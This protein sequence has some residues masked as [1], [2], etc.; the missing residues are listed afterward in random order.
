MTRKIHLFAVLFI[1]F[2]GNAQNVGIGTATPSTSALLDISS[3]TKGLLIPR[4]TNTQMNAIGSPAPGLLV[5]NL[6]DS[7]LYVR[8]NSGWTKL[9]SASNGW[10]A[11]GNDLYNSNTGNIGIG[12]NVPS[13]ARVEVNGSVGAAVAIFGADKYGVTIEAN[14]PEIGFNYFYNN[15]PK[16]LRPGYAS[17]VGMNPGTGELYLSNFGGA[18]SL[19]NFGALSEAGYRQNITILQT[20]E[21]QFAGTNNYSHFFNGPNEDVYIRSGKNAGNVII[22]DI[23]GGKIGVGMNNPTRAVLEQNGSVGTTAAIFGGDGAGISLQKNWP[24]I[25]FNHYFDGATHR[26]IGQGY[27]GV[28]GINQDN[29]N[30]YYG[31]WSYAGTSNAALAGYNSSFNVTPSGNVDIVHRDITNLEDY[32][33]I[34]LTIE[35][36]CGYSGFTQ[37]HSTWNIHNGSFAVA[38]FNNGYYGLAFW[39]KLDNSNWAQLAAIAGN[40][41]EYYQASD[42]NLKTGI[43]YMADDQLLKKIMLL[44][45]ASYNFKDAK[46]NSRSY[47]FIAQE[48]EQVFPDFVITGSKN[49]LMCYSN[50]IPVLTKG[51]QE[52]QQQIEVLQNEVAELKK[53]ILLK[54]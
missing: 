33:D 42:F 16:T 19:A 2:N 6:T 44:K 36:N 8:K 45:P 11:N 9:V 20:G 29:G 24:V 50:F 37:Y 32:T 14:N 30:L 40:G 48:V 38:D 41:G 34:G 23:P 13:H 3:T 10:S 17:V 47:G 4:M 1:S 21:I 12:T 52:Q 39:H 26:S 15:G 46:N 43:S 54:Q 5:F 27:S 31:S 18:Q 53:L 25:G 49:K 35:G 22:N 7:L 51:M 28:F